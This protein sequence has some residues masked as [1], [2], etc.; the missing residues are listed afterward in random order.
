MNRTVQIVT[1][2]EIGE[3]IAA[4]PRPWG[5]HTVNPGDGRESVIE[6]CLIGSVVQQFDVILALLETKLSSIQLHSSLAP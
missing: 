6:S 3:R 5:A 2:R 1:G 4:P